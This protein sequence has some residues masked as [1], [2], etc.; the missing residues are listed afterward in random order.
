MSVVTSIECSLPRPDIAELHQQIATEFSKRL[1]GGA[2]VL[3][4]STE[5]VLSFVMAGTVNLMFGAV[6]QA[7]K[8]NDPASMCCDNLVIYGAKHGINLRGATR[9]KGYIAI[10]GIPLSAIPPTIR[11]VSDDS[12]EYKLDPGVT[13]NP[14]Q[15]DSAGGAS[16]R[17]IATTPG[18]EF[19]LVA[20]TVVTVSTTIP[21]IDFDATVV[22]NGIIGGTN[23]ETCDQLRRRIIE[24]EA[25]NVLTT[26]E[27]WYLQQAMSY[28]GVTRVCTDECLGCCDPS[29]VAIYPFMEGVYG[30]AVTA[31]YGVPPMGV[32]DEMTL[33]M[34]GAE[35]GRGQGLAPIGMRGGFMTAYPTYVDVIGR[36]PNGC[37]AYM[38]DR[39][40]QALRTYVRTFYCVGST[41]CKDQLRAAAYL[42]IGHDPCF[43]SLDFV[44][45]SSL[46][47]EDEANAYLDCGHFLVVRSVTIPEVE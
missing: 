1:L 17:V 39:I 20:G 45:D 35:P 23:D 2:P 28:P 3:P 10:T 8:E 21:G 4:M 27:K 29:F 46:R 16:L 26:N 38:A 18:T 15:L 42:S 11:F 7:L 43:S 31:P 22:G 12:R 25:A 24:A 34:F 47:H 19:D 30:D 5:D 32:L 6:N 14:S 13:T 9:S 44:F 33:W 37:Q 41:I 36:C 40:L